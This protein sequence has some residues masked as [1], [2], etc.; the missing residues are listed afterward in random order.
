M[1][2]TAEGRQNVGILL[3]SHR[4]KGIVKIGEGESQARI[5]EKLFACKF[6]T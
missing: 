5:G 2:K 3:Y 1:S 6:F 4:R